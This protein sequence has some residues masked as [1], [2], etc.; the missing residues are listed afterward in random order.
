MKI[1]DEFPA[2][3]KESLNKKLIMY[4]VAAGM[5]LSLGAKAHAEIQYTN[6]EPNKTITQAENHETHDFLLD[7]NNDGTPEFKIFQAFST[8]YT[9]SY[10][11]YFYSYNSVLQ[12]ATNDGLS[13]MRANSVNPYVAALKSNSLISADQNFNADKVLG[14]VSY[15]DALAEGMWPGAGQKFMGV[16]FKIEENIHYGW[17]R[18]SVADNCGSFTVYDYAY[19]DEAGQAIKAGQT[20]SSLSDELTE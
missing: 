20:G 2:L 4:S 9:F 19:E 11:Y 16:K 5:T 18:L 13:V 8:T 7:L 15:Y 14:V 17:I 10:S 12:V 1:N 6:I 3:K